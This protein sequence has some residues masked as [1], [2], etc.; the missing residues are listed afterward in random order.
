MP[1]VSPSVQ[2]EIC[3][4]LGTSKDRKAVPSLVSLLQTKASFWKRSAGVPDSVRLRAPLSG[5][6]RREN[7]VILNRWFMLRVSR[8]DR[9][10]FWFAYCRAHACLPRHEV[11][12]WAR[13]LEGA[14]LDSNFR[15][16][17]NRDRRCVLR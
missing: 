13:K 4:A 2:E 6:A 17:R 11:R 16:W 12:D 10:R 1:P 8:S 14:S 3:I 15:F 9:L 5:R 7:L